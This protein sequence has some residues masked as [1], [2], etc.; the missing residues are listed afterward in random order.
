MN[1]NNQGLGPLLG[2]VAQ[3]AKACMDHRVSR[4]D[5]TRAQ[6]HVLLY[7][8]SKGGQASQSELT[9]LR[10]VKPST[11]NGVLDRLEEKGFVQ[12]SISGADARC[13]LVTL[14]PK[15]TRQQALFQQSF[16]EVEQAMTQDFTPEE[17][18]LLSALLER[19]IQNLKEDQAT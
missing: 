14:T 18:A 10:R 7:L 8:H 13:R 4:Y 16:L 5:V 11:M 6:A 19:I 2:Y 1:P 17:E 9:G 15:G 12:R 3:L